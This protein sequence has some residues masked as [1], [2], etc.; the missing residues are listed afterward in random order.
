MG[1]CATMQLMSITFMAITLMAVS[2][3][4]FAHASIQALRA[5]AAVPHDNPSRMLASTGPVQAG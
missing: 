5:P 1:A 3:A 4:P 2:A